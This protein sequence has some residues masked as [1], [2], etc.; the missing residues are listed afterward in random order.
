MRTSGPV[1]AILLALA[2]CTP[3][4][5]PDPVPVVRDPNVDVTPGLNEKEP[6]TCGAKKFAQLVGQ[7]QT[8]VAMAGITQEYRIID[9]FSIVTQEYSPDRI[10]VNVDGAG[11]ITHLTCG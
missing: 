10:N 3:A 4:P 5:E 7:P 6:D 11:I 9:P 8:A 2:A 1:L